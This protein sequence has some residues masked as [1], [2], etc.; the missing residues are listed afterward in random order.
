MREPTVIFCP[1]TSGTSL[2]G[3][4]PKGSDRCSKVQGFKAV[5]SLCSVEDVYNYVRLK[6]RVQGFRL[7]LL[8]DVEVRHAHHGRI[9]LFNSA[10][11]G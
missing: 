3:A 7:M 6:V 9:V 8:Q 4:T 2:T 5:Q 10:A 11:L 1:V